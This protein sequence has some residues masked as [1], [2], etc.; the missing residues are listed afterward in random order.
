MSPFSG[1]FLT[2]SPP[3]RRQPG[4]VSLRWVKL[5]K[6]GRQ[7]GYSQ[8]NAHINKEALWSETVRH[9]PEEWDDGM[10]GRHSWHMKHPDD[11]S[12]SLY[13]LLGLE[14][15]A[16]VEHLPRGQ[17]QQTCH[18]EDA[19]VHHAWMG[20]FWKKTKTWCSTHSAQTTFLQHWSQK[21]RNVS[22]YT[23]CDWR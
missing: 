3:A 21:G 14:V 11:Q 2:V 15:S 9:S 13:Q 6:K 22:K 20:G 10:K 4:V 1:I 5:T 19:E 23:K 8:N 17:P 7:K 18:G 12:A 16:Q